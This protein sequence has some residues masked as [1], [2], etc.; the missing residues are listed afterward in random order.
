ME[1][2]AVKIQSKF[3][4]FQAR[5][6]VSVLRQEKHAATKIQ[7]GYRGFK[8]RKQVQRMRY[9]AAFSS[10]TSGSHMSSSYK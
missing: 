4:Q 10:S 9:I 5:Q 3:R 6:R 2:A 8:A 1:Q 7:A